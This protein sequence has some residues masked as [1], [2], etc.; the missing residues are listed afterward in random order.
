[1][2]NEEKKDQN[3]NTR[4]NFSFF[5]IQYS[6]TLLIKHLSKLYFDW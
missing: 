3:Q 5:I 1:M 6:K 4:V 2:K